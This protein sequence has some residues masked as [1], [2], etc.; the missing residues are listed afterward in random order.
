MNY[1]YPSGL[2]LTHT[3]THTQ[4]T[5]RQACFQNWSFRILSGL[6]SP[7]GGHTLCI[8]K[9]RST[10]FFFHSFQTEKICTIRLRSLDM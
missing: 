7:L 8:L 3:H 4:I 10:K 5:Q 9:K 2:F 1:V 6:P